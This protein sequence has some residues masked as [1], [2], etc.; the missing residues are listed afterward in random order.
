MISGCPASQPSGAERSSRAAA[1][2]RIGEPDLDLAT[3]A[4]ISPLSNAMIA[5]AGDAE[6][7]AVALLAARR[8]VVR[9]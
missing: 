2:C 7:A 5:S 4:S 6:R 9:K 1:R 8:S 3:A